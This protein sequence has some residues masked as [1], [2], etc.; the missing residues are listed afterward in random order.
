MHSLVNLQ[1]L[2]G[3]IAIIAVAT[4]LFSARGLFTPYPSRTAKVVVDE[5]KGKGKG[6]GNMPTL[7][8]RSTGPGV[9]T[10]TVTKRAAVVRAGLLASALSGVAALSIAP[11]QEPRF[12]LP[13]GIGL[14]TLAAP[15]LWR[16][17][18]AVWWL[19]CA[20]NLG[21]GGF[22]AF[23]HQAGVIPSLMGHATSPAHH[24]LVYYASYMPPRSMAGS[25]GSTVYDFH[26]AE[27][28]EEL[29]AMFTPLAAKL[30]AEQLLL[31]KRK[32]RCSASLSDGSCVAD[33]AD[34]DSDGT[35]APIL[36]L[37]MP[38]SVDADAVKKMLFESHQ[39]QLGTRA[40]TEYAPHFSGEHLPQHPSELS[41]LV[42]PAT[43]FETK[44]MND[45]L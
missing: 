32:V 9:V 10:I 17:G 2:F 3:P 27:T 42:Y 16:Q 37:A 25:R 11:H 21:L 28:L 24:H 8:K 23:V 15:T 5:G 19:W 40:V 6:K 45:L 39:I 35:M 14:V 41:L 12:L 26:K 43:L 1:V 7:K 33:D 20:F 29:S 34:D 18:K 31:R 30:R 4:G 38:G 22:Y 13:A 44:E 36:S